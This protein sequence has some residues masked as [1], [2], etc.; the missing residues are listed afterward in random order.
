MDWLD[1]L[2][3]CLLSAM[4]SGSVCWITGFNAGWY[5]CYYDT[6]E[7]MQDTTVSVGQHITE[8][9]NAKLG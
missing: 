2:T 1:V 4:T 9:D 8:V 7:A 3:L 6:Q 5:R